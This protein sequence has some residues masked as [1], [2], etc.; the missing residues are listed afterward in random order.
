MVLILKVLGENTHF[1]P[2]AQ[3]FMKNSVEWFPPA[4]PKGLEGNITLLKYC[5]I[6][7]QRFWIL[8][9]VLA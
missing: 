3:I 1:F 8:L 2:V 6:N 7:Q 9:N 5:K 4:T